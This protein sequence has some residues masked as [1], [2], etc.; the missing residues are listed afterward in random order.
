MMQVKLNPT[1]KQ[2]DYAFTGRKL[3]KLVCNICKEEWI[4]DHRKLD[5]KKSKML[6][7]IKEHKK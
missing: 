5:H 4:F 3:T 7:H 6:K 1:A 2:S